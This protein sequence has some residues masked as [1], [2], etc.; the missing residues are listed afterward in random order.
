MSSDNSEV[1][2]EFI[3]I[4]N[5]FTNDLKISY[6]ELSENFETIDYQAYYNYC[7]NIYPENFF[8]VLYE[9]EDLFKNDETKYLLPNINFETIMCDESLS[10]QSKKTI[11]KYLQLLLFCICNNVNNKKD[12]GDANY[13]FEAINED[14]LHSKIQETMKEMKNIF[15]NMNNEDNSN[16]PFDEFTNVFSDI[17]NLENMFE[18]DN[19]GNVFSGLSGEPN[20][21]EGMFENMMD[22]DKMKEHLSGIM[23]GKIGS[24]AKEIAEEATKELGLEGENMDENSQHEFMKNL[25]KNPTKILSIVKNI[26]SKLEEKFKSGEMKESELLEEAQEIMSKMKDMPG[27]KNMMSSMGLN[28]GGKFDFKSMAS[29]MQQN[30]RSAKMKERMQAKLQKNRQQ[31]Q[32]NNEPVGNLQQVEENTFVWNDDNSNPNQPFNKSSSSASSK[33]KKSNKKKNKKKNKNKN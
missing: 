29:K 2:E 4:V 23:N 19:S 27:L 5:D 20:L 3:K 14:E 16:N 6:P 10:A 33:P 24:L 21:G 8:N 22:A 7:K 17:S 18:G 13:L 28:P 15:L 25:F 32:Q 1:S 11:W 31:Q 30:M 9:N 12:F 26:G